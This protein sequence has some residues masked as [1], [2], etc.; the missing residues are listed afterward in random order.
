MTPSQTANSSKSVILIG[1]MGSG[2]TECGAALSKLLEL[3]LIDTDELVTSAVGKSIAR[4]F[5][6]E[7]EEVFRQLE[8]VAVDE[9]VRSGPAV[10]ACGGGVVLNP[11]NVEKIRGM[12]KVVYLEVSAGEAGRRLGAGGGRPLLTG[13]DVVG[14]LARMMKDRAPLYETA[15][16]IKVD[17][18]GTVDEVSSRVLEAL[19]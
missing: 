18:E 9:A 3:P 5:D 11:E 17:G 7:G 13:K 6:E 2:K 15:A 10:V 19:G 1:P 14:E 12:G 4:I 16:H 8:R